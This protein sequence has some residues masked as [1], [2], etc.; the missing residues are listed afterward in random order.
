MV[1]DIR[2]ELVVPIE[3]VRSVYA[4][5][6]VQSLEGLE[7]VKR[8]EPEFLHKSVEAEVV[9]PL[10]RRVSEIVTVVNPVATAIESRVELQPVYE[11]EEETQRVTA[12]TEQEV[13]VEQ[14]S[15]GEELAA[16]TIYGDIVLQP[17]YVPQVTVVRVPI[18][19]APP[20]K[21]GMYPAP[22]PSP[23]PVPVLGR[24]KGA[25]ATA[26]PKPKTVR[27]VVVL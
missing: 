26:P 2:G 22:L 20:Q 27:E 8:L 6:V 12:E 14:P 1:K 19:S 9:V 13:V 4:I 23:P 15:E 5:Q 3:K 25:G 7:K 10:E 18:G 24:G 21:E 17:V 16:Q 11:T